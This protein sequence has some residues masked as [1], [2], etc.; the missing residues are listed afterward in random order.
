[1]STLCAR[2]AGSF[3]RMKVTPMPTMR[4]EAAKPDARCAVTGCGRPRRHPI[5]EVVE[6]AQVGEIATIES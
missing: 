3:A 1:M 4:D 2:A 5:H 6:Q